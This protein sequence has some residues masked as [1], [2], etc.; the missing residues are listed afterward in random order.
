MKPKSDSWLWPFFSSSNAIAAANTRALVLE[1]A[2][3]QL[4]EMVTYA[5]AAQQV[6]SLTCPTMIKAETALGLSTDE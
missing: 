3:R 1:V 5:A 6:M 4:Y 2:L